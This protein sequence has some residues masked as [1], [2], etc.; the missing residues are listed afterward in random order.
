MLFPVE[1]LFMFSVACVVCVSCVVLKYSVWLH[2]DDKKWVS[3][4]STT[5]SKPGKKIYC[6]MSFWFDAVKN[7]MMP[8]KSPVVPAML[9][10]YFA[11]LLLNLCCFLFPVWENSTEG[12]QSLCAIRVLW[13]DNHQHPKIPYYSILHI[14]THIHTH[15]RGR[16]SHHKPQPFKWEEQDKQRDELQRQKYLAHGNFRL[17]Q[18][19]TAAGIRNMTDINI[20]HSSTLE[21]IW[22]KVTLKPWST[23]S[24]SNFRNTVTPDSSKQQKTREEKWLSY[25][26]ILAMLKYVGGVD[27]I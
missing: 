8:Q 14:H 26:S 23:T 3:F 1:E 9:H 7:K 25:L 18:Q 19:L 4:V 11:V 13:S 6:S 16:F 12:S 21:I 27:S 2:L 10:I 24:F 5:L 15:K 20:K 22:D 17:L